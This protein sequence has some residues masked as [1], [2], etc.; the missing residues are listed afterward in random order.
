MT[1][2]WTDIGNATIVLVW[3]ANPSENHPACMAHINRARAK[4]ATLVVVD[5]RKTRTALQADQYI[6]IRPGTDIA[7]LELRHRARSSR[8]WRARS[9]TPA[10][11]AKF[12]EFLNQSGAGSF[13]TDGDATTPSSL[14]AT[15]PGS[16]KYTDARF[17]VNATGVTTFVRRSWPPRRILPL[18]ER[19]RTRSSPTSRRRPRLSDAD[20]NTVYNRLK[21][22][23]APYTLAVTADICGCTQQEILDLAKYFID[24]QPLLERR[25]RRSGSG[26]RIAGSERGRLQGPHDALR[27]GHHAAHR[28]QPERQGL[29]RTPDAHGQHGSCGRRHQRAARHPQRPG[30]DRHG[31][32]LRQH[33]RVL[34]Q[35]DGADRR[36]DANAFG[37]YMDACGATR[38]RARATRALDERLVRRRVQ[39]DRAPERW[40]CSSAAS[41][42]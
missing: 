26:V 5:P 10:V 15:V 40:G 30:F 34:E 2:H 1:N 31:S 36:T 8:R 35:P 17:L 28:R 4:G 27:D 39:H 23:V 22:H 20:P 11:S 33:P 21:A 24:Q 13:Y 42:T 19:P 41:S 29:R 32:A 6:R 3:G 12:F 9:M 14:I 16:S 37:K 7:M 38:C 25:S 18:A